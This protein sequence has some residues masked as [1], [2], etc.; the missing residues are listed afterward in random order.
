MEHIIKIN[1][2]KM[3]YLVLNSTVYTLL[4]TVHGRV[5]CIIA[6][7][8]PIMDNPETNKHFNVLI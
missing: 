1:D 4:F 3:Y 7:H 8:A 2:S 6:C 5:V